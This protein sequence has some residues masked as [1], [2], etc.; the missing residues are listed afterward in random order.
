MGPPDQN[1]GSAPGSLYLGLFEPTCSSR[2]SHCRCDYFWSVL[3]CCFLCCSYAWLGANDKTG[4]S[5]YRWQDGTACKSSS[6]LRL[7]AP[8]FFFLV[9]WS[10]IFSNF[11]VTDCSHHK[12]KTKKKLNSAYEDSACL[13]LTNVHDPK[14]TAHKFL[15]HVCESLSQQTDFLG[16][17]GGCALS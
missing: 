17:R 10:M 4:D 2:K 5:D 1:P 11:F 7:W 6:S 9:L 14:N 12:K 3:M 8:E 15:T 13:A 16:G